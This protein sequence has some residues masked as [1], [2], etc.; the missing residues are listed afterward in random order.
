MVIPGSYSDFGDYA[1]TS[2]FG[3]KKLIF[4]QT[5]DNVVA[6]HDHSFDTL[7]NVEEIDFSKMGKTKSGML[8]QMGG[9][10]ASAFAD[11]HLGVE[12]QVGVKEGD[13]II[14]V[15]ADEET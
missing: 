6:F 1:F 15:G 9:I 4:E 2:S 3:L 10:G 7:P 12:T 11:I 13:I 8:T 5:G 14:P